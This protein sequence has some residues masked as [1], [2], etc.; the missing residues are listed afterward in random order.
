V[1][2]SYSVAISPRLTF[3]ASLK[4]LIYFV[5]GA[6]LSF[7]FIK[8]W[9]LALS[10]RDTQALL[11]GLVMKLKT[12]GA[13]ALLSYWQKLKG[14]LRIPRSEDVDLVDIAPILSNTLVYEKVGDDYSMRFFG[15]E[16]VRRLGMDLTGSKV[17]EFVDQPIGRLTMDHLNRVSHGPLILAVEFKSQTEQGPIIDIEQ[18]MLPVGDN[19]GNPLCILSH[20]ARTTG[21]D[22]TVT[23]ELA[24]SHREITGEQTL[25]L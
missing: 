18:I 23:I 3:K 5:H 25:N 15:T 21:Q 16:F 1:Y 2:R 24:A 13:R 4:L 22:S 9:F 12:V 20:I 14:D 8:T 19:E 10:Q 17:S 6:T 7:Y 11:Q